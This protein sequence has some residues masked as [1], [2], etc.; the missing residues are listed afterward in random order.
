MLLVRP[1]LHGGIGGDA[2]AGALQIAVAEHDAGGGFPGE[3][4]KDTRS[5]GTPKFPG[6]RG[7]MAERG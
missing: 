1:R 5:R 3:L 7:A 4:Q 2:G 6:I